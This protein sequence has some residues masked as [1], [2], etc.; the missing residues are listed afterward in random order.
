MAKLIIGGAWFSSPLSLDA[1]FYVY[2]FGNN[3]TG[4]MKSFPCFC[5]TKRENDKMS[6]FFPKSDHFVMCT[7]T[8]RELESF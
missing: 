2:E 8:L 6:V 7:N 5:V 4:E 1:Q 3:A